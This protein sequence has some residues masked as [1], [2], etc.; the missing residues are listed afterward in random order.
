MTRWLRPTNGEGHLVKRT[1]RAEGSVA[2]SES[3]LLYILSGIG[4]WL[5]M[6]GI[7]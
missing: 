1:A 3:W 5:G 2:G 6:A 7:A 4:S